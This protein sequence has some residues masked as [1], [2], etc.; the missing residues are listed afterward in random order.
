MNAGAPL[1]PLVGDAAVVD[2]KA[3]TLRLQT[4]SFKTYLLVLI[5]QCD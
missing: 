4:P 1:T 3:G 2:P 5:R